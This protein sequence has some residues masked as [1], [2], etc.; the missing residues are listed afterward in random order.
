MEEKWELKLNLTKSIVQKVHK[1]ILQQHSNG[2]KSID[3][4][5]VIAQNMLKQ[6]S[7]SLMSQV[8]N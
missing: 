8:C 5:S 1:V 7:R 6:M 3:F 2:I 4:E